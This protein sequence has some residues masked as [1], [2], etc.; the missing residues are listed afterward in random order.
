MLVCTLGFTACNNSEDTSFPMQDGPMEIR[1]TIAG[2]A[3]TRATVDGDWTVDDEVALWVQDESQGIYRYHVTDSRGSMTG[4]YY[5]SN[6]DVPLNIQAIYPYRAVGE[7]STNLSN[8]S[9]SVEKAQNEDKGYDGSDLLCSELIS[10]S[11]GYVPYI[12][13]YHQTAKIVVNVKQD[14]LPASINAGPNDITLTIGESDILTLNGT[15]TPT[16]SGSSDGWFGTWRLGST[17]GS[18]TPHL[19]TT[20]PTGCFATY[21]ALVIPQ[22]VSAGTRLFTFTAEK[23]GTSYGTFHYALQNDANWQAGYV[24]T[25]DITIFH[26]G[27]KVQV[28]EGIGWE[29][30]TGGSGSVE[31][32]V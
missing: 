15:F 20:T 14:G 11:G 6:K 8:I 17:Q 30:G 18:I 29:N 13:F 3:D 27:L 7:G 32:P 10:A 9:W 12:N 4:N 5:W 2:G 19:A 22:N 28:S 24:Y 26:Y 31:L 23:N 25:Y 21:E 16:K 1:A